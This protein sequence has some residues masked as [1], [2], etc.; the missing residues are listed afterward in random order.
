MLVSIVLDD[1]QRA[2]IVPA[3]R[4][5]VVPWEG[6]ANRVIT[7]QM[8]ENTISHIYLYIVQSSYHIYVDL[9]L[10]TG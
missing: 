6:E 8:A 4:T 5:S 9:I 2:F 10:N 3:P 7:H 1:P